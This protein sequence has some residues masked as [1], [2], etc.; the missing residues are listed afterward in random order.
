MK[1]PS[2]VRHVV[3]KK[4]PF[5]STLCMNA[6]RSTPARAMNS[7]NVSLA[8]IR[9]RMTFDC[10]GD[11]NTATA[12]RVSLHFKLGSLVFKAMTAVGDVVAC[13]L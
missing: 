10:T 4:E 5:S 8:R 9:K 11:Q 2:Q 3:R 6:G 13:E 1:L 7:A 12:G